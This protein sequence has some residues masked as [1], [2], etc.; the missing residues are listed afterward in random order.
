MG[1][2]SN[3]KLN[4][5]ELSGIYFGVNGDFIDNKMGMQICLNASNFYRSAANIQ[6]AN[7]LFQV[8]QQGG[9]EQPSSC[10]PSSLGIHSPISY[11]PN[12]RIFQKPSKTHLLDL[13]LGQIHG[14]SIQQLIHVISFFL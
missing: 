3:W 8:S 4:P 5:T 6:E 12:L 7:C 13:S 9:K 2:N 11:R 1:V 10:L 14:L